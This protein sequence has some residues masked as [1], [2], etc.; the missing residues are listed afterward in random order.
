[1]KYSYVK[2]RETYDSIKSVFNNYNTNNEKPNQDR[3]IGSFSLAMPFLL[4]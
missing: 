4:Q 2:T 3:D 1:M